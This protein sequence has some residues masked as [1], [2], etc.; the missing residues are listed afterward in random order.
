M[1]NNEIEY[2]LGI[3][4]EAWEGWMGVRKKKKAPIT[5]CAQVRLIKK[6]MKMANGNVDIFNDIVEQS[7]LNG[8]IGLFD[9]KPRNNNYQNSYTPQADPSKSKDIYGV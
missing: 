8:W 6:G 1:G 7:W 5:G 4:M 9:L 2:P 3:D